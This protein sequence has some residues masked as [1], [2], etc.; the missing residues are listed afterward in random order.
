MKL[1]ADRAVEADSLEVAR[2]AR[3]LQTAADR[4]V[5]LSTNCCRSRAR[6]GT[7]LERG[8]GPG[9]DFSTWPGWPSKPAP[10]TLGYLRRWPS[11]STLASR[12]LPGPRPSPAAPRPVVL[13][14]RLLMREALVNLIDNAV[15][16][17]PQTLVTV[18]AGG[19]RSATA[20]PAVVMIEDLG[21]G[22]SPQRRGSLQ[23][24]LPRHSRQGDQFHRKPREP[25]WA[26][27]SCARSSACTTAPSASKTCRPG[28]LPLTSL[29]GAPAGSER[30]PEQCL[31][32]PY[33]CE[34][35]GR[36]A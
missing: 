17:V 36:A 19:R 21:P 22:I 32:D 2:H 35:G 16:Y 3:E 11:G 6:A 25:G 27:Q 1:H 15:K 5:R 20:A 18:R 29:S 4:A 12:V 9:E 34:A 10:R 24:L 26:W 8:P 23:A 7:V 13:L 33:P 31:R 30:R 14:N 28:T